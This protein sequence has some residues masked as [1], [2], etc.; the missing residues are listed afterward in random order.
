MLARTTVTSAPDHLPA[1]ERKAQARSTEE[2]FL[3]RVD[4]QV[5]SSFDSKEPA[6]T[7]GSV[8]KKAYPVVMV[9]VVD[10]KDGAIE[11]IKA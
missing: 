7:A 3:L 6:I 8:I 1:G 10:S 9:T 5:K 2:R 11:V 4:G